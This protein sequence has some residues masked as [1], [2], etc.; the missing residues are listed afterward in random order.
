M[1]SYMMVRFTR[2]MHELAWDINRKYNVWPCNSEINKS[3]HKIMIKKSIKKKFTI[4]V[5]KFKILLHW[6]IY[7]SSSYKAIILKKIKYIFAL[8]KIDAMLW[9]GHIYFKKIFEISMILNLKALVMESFDMLHD[10]AIIVS[11]NNIINI[12]NNEDR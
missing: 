12:H 8:I 5:G 7:Y 1:V 4:N 2:L 3:S 10:M 9:T 11:N 6:M